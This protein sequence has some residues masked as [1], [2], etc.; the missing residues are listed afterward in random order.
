MEFLVPLSEL[1]QRKPSQAPRPPIANL[2]V[3]AVI[4]LL[5]GSVFQEFRWRSSIMVPQSQMAQAEKDVKAGDFKTAVTMFEKLADNNN[6]LA[7]YWVAHMTELGLGIPR[8]PAKAIELYKKA[9]AQDVA[10]AELRLGEIYLHGDLVLPDFA[11]AK[12]Y[13]EKAAYHGGPRAAMLLGQMYHDGIGMPADQTEAYAWSEVATL[14]GSI[15]ASRDRDAS[16]HGLSE[17]DQ[18]SAI[19]R[20]QEILKIIKGE[21]PPTQPPKSN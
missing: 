9:A 18:K 13:L 21:M 14:E 1:K 4:G 12:T 2:L 8:D 10:A 17:A 15:F 11:Q 19:A 3:Y 5:V 6:P 20:A 7:E 16:F